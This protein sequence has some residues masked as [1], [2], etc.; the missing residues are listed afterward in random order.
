RRFDDRSH[1]LA[2]F[3]DQLGGSYAR[4]AGIYRPF[5][6]YYFLMQYLP[7]SR[8]GMT[9]IDILV[10]SAVTLMIF[11]AVYGLLRAS[12]QVSTL[13]S[14]TAAA[15][16]IA[17]SQMEYIRSLSYDSIGTVGGIP[18]GLIA[19]NA[20]TTEDNIDYAVRTF[21]DYY[22]DPADGTGSSDTNG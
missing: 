18:A 19:Q 11:L 7:A 22:D 17:N 14:E 1:L 2:H 5:V 9:L 8:R 6:R 13:A 21:I 3:K 15:T 12:A 10:G 4:R 16:A 20:T